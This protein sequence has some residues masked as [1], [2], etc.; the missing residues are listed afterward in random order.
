MVFPLL[1]S[2]MVNLQFFIGML[3]NR[4]K[5]QRFCLGK[6][7]HLGV[8]RNEARYNHDYHEKVGF[9][10]CFSFNYLCMR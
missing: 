2:P 8:Y 1:I 4:F 10:P 3:R 9:I 5:F 7:L 6:E